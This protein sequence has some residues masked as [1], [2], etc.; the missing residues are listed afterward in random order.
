MTR[1]EAI[2]AERKARRLRRLDAAA[3]AVRAV[4]GRHEVPIGFFGSYA[5]GTPGP[6]SDLDVLVLGHDVSRV[7]E[8]FRR[9]I[10]RVGVDQDIEIDLRLE[11]NA[12]HL[13]MDMIS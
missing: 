7:T 6:N 13:S 9:D 11:R 3:A 5:R 1:L 2:I 10:E 8:A 4:A 12:P